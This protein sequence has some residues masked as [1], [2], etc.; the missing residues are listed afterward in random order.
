MQRT[1]LGGPGREME[2]IG[3]D[4][5]LVTFQP[6]GM[7][8]EGQATPAFLVNVPLTDTLSSHP[9]TLPST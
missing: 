8:P 9:S 2:D 4:Y 6:S 5:R 1:S 3:P 7:V